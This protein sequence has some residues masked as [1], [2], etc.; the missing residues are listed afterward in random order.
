[1]ALIAYLEAHADQLDEDAKRRLHSNPLR[2]LDTKNPAMKALVEGAPRLLDF[3]GEASLAHLNALK[4][5][6]DANGVAYTINPRLVRGLDY[7]NLTVF[8]FVTD[9]LGS[10]GTICAG[11]RYDDLIAQIGGKAAPAVGWA[12][13]VE[14]V[15]ELLKEQAPM[16]PPAP[17]VYAI[18]PEAQAMPQVMQALSG[19]RRAGVSVQMHAGAAETWGSMKSQ[20]KKADASG[21]QWAL[22]FGADEMARG[23]VTLKAL[24]D[25]VGAQSALALSALSAWAQTLLAPESINLQ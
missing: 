17:W 21:A 8:E 3:L 9:S 5:I 22:I 10:Q 24:R 7:Y 14:R 16:A 11:G 2:I 18:V 6:L 20:F 23:E 19:V 12:F 4:N 1:M 13:G 15:L 25:G